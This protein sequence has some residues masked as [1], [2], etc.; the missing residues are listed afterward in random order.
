MTVA[1]LRSRM[2]HDEFVMWT[3]YYARKAQTLELERQKAGV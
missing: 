1:E 3:R 2:G